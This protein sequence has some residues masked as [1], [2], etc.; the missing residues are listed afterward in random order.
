MSTRLEQIR[1]RLYSEF[2]DYARP[3]HF[4]DYEHCDECAEHDETMQSADLETLTAA[5]MGTGGWSPLSFLTE[6][7][8]GYYMPRLME[9]ALIEDRNVHGEPFA[10]LIMFHLNPT[11]DYDRF[12]AYTP[13]QCEA[14]LDALL[15]IQKRH[16]ETIVEYLFDEDLE[17]AI[18]YWRSRI[19]ST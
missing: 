13:S 9:L 16:R 2:S 6:E 12:S 1:D 18:E 7:A 17:P 14:I 19:G 15:Y 11:S 5:H 8:F 3:E 4:T 10:T